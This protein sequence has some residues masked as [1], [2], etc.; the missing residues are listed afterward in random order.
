M[1]GFRESLEQKR[2]V[3][4]IPVI[5]DIKIKSPKEGNLFLNITPLE[6]LS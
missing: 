3:G 1:K 2:A 6:L 5:P 4:S